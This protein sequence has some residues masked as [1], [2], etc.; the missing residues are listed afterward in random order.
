MT[1]RNG[2]APFLS[3]NCHHKQKEIWGVCGGL[4]LLAIA[5]LPPQPTPTPQ[6]SRGPN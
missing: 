2:D 5:H 4:Y 1:A 6:P 3:P